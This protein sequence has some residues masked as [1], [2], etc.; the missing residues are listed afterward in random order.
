MMMSDADDRAQL[1]AFDESSPK[2][3]IILT[4]QRSGSSLVG[5]M[6]SR[7]PHAFYL[8]EPLDA[9]YV[10]M[11]GINHGWS[12]PSDITHYWNGTH[13]YTSHYVTLHS[14]LYC[15]GLSGLS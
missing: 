13:R 9:I 8:F 12:V 10:A 3:L 15:L 7:N 2:S 14:Q 4:Y 5:D 1:D 6:F 11:Y